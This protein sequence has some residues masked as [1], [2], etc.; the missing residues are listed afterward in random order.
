MFSVDFDVVK[1]VYLYVENGI[2]FLGSYWVIDIKLWFL[3]IDLI[4]LVLG[5]YFKDK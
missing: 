5:I 2:L 4:K 3:F 1:L